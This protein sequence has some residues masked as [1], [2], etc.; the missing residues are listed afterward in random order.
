MPNRVMQTLMDKST[1]IGTYIASISTAIGGLMSLNNLALLIG[2]VV[3]IV[4]GYVQYQVWTSRR[5]QDHEWHTARMSELQRRAAAVVE[6][7]HALADLHLVEPVRAGD[8]A[9]PGRPQGGAE[10]R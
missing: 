7:D 2:I 4:L 9:D 8:P 6:S 3:T 1:T 5:K 10:A